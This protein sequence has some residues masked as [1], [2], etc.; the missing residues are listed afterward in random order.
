MQ[1]PVYIRDRD[2]IVFKLISS[3]E[4]GNIFPD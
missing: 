3:K 1:K 2:D 4:E